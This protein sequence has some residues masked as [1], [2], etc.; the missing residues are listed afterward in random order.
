MATTVS[1]ATT[2]V[3]PMLRGA[4]PGAERLTQRGQNYFEHIPQAKMAQAKQVVPSAPA[5][6]GLE[7]QPHPLAKSIMAMRLYAKSGRCH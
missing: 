3:M 2:R 4:A 7:Q 6:N 5:E 1:R